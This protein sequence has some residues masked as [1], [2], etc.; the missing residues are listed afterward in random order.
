MPCDIHVLCACAF[1]AGVPICVH[2]FREYERQLWDDDWEKRASDDL[3]GGFVTWGAGRIGALMLDTAEFVDT[4][5][6]EGRETKLGVTSEA[7]LSPDQLAALQAALTTPELVVVL[8]I[9]EVRHAQ[10]LDTCARCIR[11]VYPEPAESWLLM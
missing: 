1:C 11:L 3:E 8:V 5:S 9:S 6:P 2:R 10:L 7:L 4:P